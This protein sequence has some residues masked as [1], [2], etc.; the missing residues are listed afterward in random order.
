MVVTYNGVRDEHGNPAIVKMVGE[1]VRVLKQRTDLVPAGS[2]PPE[3]GYVGN[4]PLRTAVMILSDFLENDGMAA[5][6]ATHYV[7]HVLAK[8]PKGGWSFTEDDV[9][10]QV[11]AVWMSEG[12]RRN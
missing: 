2:K 5:R 10:K 9:A 12:A 1:E 8:Q 4:G 3:W 11:H 6:L 7:T